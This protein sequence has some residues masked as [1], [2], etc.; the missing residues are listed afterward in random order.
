MGI[1]PSP[2]RGENKKKL[3]PPPSFSIFDP[4]DPFSKK[5]KTSQASVSARVDLVS[6]RSSQRRSE[7]PGSAG[8]RGRVGG[9]QVSLTSN[10]MEVLYWHTPGK[11]SMRI[12]KSREMW[13]AG[14][15]CLNS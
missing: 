7:G 12:G 8:Q 1:F 15:E 9:A 14:N 10:G 2:G 6:E 3:K 13:M 5:K 11:S 4:N